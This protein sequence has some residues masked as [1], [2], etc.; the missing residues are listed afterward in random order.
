M[1]D[2]PVY[3]Q[4]QQLHAARRDSI[5]PSDQDGEVER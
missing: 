4:T 1:S 3:S 2:Y 5:W